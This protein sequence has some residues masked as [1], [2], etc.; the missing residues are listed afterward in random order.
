MVRSSQD[1]SLDAAE[2]TPDGGGVIGFNQRHSVWS[3]VV[4]VRVQRSVTHSLARCRRR[5]SRGC[6]GFVCL[7]SSWRKGADKCT[8]TVVVATRVVLVCLVII[9][10]DARIASNACVFCSASRS[11]VVLIGD[12]G[13]TRE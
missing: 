6:R 7:G 1:A 2:R 3:S 4:I 10:N 5:C 8:L 12:K 11:T 13:A 9:D